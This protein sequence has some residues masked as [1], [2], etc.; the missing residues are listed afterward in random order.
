MN[1]TKARSVIFINAICLD[2][3]SRFALEQNGQLA[4]DNSVIRAH[5]AHVASLS[6]GNRPNIYLNG[7]VY[8]LTQ[9]GYDTLISNGATQGAIRAQRESL[10]DYIRPATSGSV[11]RERTA[12]RNATTTQRISNMIEIEIDR[13]EYVKITCKV[14]DSFKNWIKEH[15]EL[16][17][18]ESDYGRDT[19]RNWDATNETKFYAVNLQNVDA[20][21]IGSTN[22]ITSS[23]INS[24]LIKL[25]CAS[26]TN[27]YTVKYRG[28][29]A[30]ET[31]QS[32]GAR[33]GETVTAFYK[34]YVRPFNFKVAVQFF[35]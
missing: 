19:A 16:R 35:V 14:H 1:F 32:N 10:P 8:Q 6:R 28:L 22:I 11:Y 25:A 31:V 15:G 18:F 21:H 29:V 3:L 17:N 2:I 34:S 23:G 7:D 30:W 13:N 24:L 9:R 27:E 26:E 5:G 4:R 33:L 12:R 20:G